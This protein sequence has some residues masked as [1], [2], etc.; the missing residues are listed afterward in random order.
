MYVRVY[1]HVQ[2]QPHVMKH[3]TRAW[4]SHS[5]ITRMRRPITRH[6][7]VV[8]DFA[9]KSSMCKRFISITRPRIVTTDTTTHTQRPL[10][11]QPRTVLSFK[12]CDVVRV[13]VFMSLVWFCKTCHHLCTKVNLSLHRDTRARAHAHADTSTHIHKHTHTYTHKH[14]QTS[15][16]THIHIHSYTHIYTHCHRDNTCIHTLAR[17]RARTPIKTETT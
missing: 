1:E 11:M 3:T 10:C 4:D 12:C 16:H 2:L 9:K 7:N 15:I 6:M 8:K 17:I 13:N 14:T 5:Q